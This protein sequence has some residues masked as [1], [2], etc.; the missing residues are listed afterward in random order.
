[1]KRHAATLLGGAAVVGLL[2]GSFGVPSV[3]AEEPAPAAKTDKADKAEKAPAVDLVETLASMDQ[4]KT[5]SDLIK[6]AGM[7]DTLKSGKYTVFAPTEGAFASVPKEMMDALKKDPAKMK[8][9]VMNHVTKGK[10]TTSDLKK[11]GKSGKGVAML[12]G[13]QFPVTIEKKL[14]PS[15]GEAAIVKTN[16][17]AKNGVIQGIDKVLVPG[18]PPTKPPATPPAR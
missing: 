15:V 8:A 14:L 4:F 6:D 2:F 18:T 9:L 17:E 3:M 16:R 11:L 10:V 13:T 1:M 5:F 12:S 7:A